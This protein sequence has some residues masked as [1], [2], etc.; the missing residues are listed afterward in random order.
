MKAS[1][2]AITLG[3]VLLAGCAA[4]G[5]RTPKPA[6]IDASAL[7]GVSGGAPAP[8]LEDRWWRAFK[9][10]Q[11]DALI[12]EA[13]AASPT[14]ASAAGRLAGAEALA[15]AARGGRLP[16][17][18]LAANLERQRLSEKGLYPPPYGG[19]TLNLGQIGVDFSYEI[20]LVG[21]VRAQVKASEATSNAARSDLVAARLGVAAAVART[22]LKLARN[23]AL[24]DT[25]NEALARR[26]EQL[27]L[28]EQ[29]VRAGLDSEFETEAARAALASADADLAAA[30]E[31]RV[32]LVNE[33]SAL[34]GAGPARAAALTRPVYVLP[35]PLSLPAELPASLVGRRPDVAA[36]RARVEAAA[37]SVR[38]AETGFYPNIN[39]SAFA[40]FQSI[41]LGSLIS[42][43]TRSWN[44]GP[45]LSLPLFFTGRL[46][47]ELGARDADYVGAVTRYNSTVIEAFHEVADALASLRLLEREQ[48]ASAVAVAALEHAN[49]L[50][51][52]RYRA[53]LTNYLTVLIAEQ[54]LLAQRRLAVDLEA[55]RAELAVALIRALGGGFSA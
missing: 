46:R 45:A 12:D 13:L 33:L 38:V 4:M 28:T 37:A 24:A 53:G 20:D 7:A 26:R 30:D 11:L 10:P 41:E 32:L 54:N 42:S 40:G 3:C 9:D 18:T 8:A 35:A 55:R 16:T 5:P 48:S 27:A 1:T 14:I 51:L 50:A 2:G 23:H 44:A 29:R 52:V 47:G 17:S 36:E 22:Y 39:L 19:S 34:L 49:A 6:L 31:E 15:T 25:L 43:G 21:R